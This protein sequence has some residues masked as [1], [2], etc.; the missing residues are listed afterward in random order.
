MNEASCVAYGL[1]LER[2]AARLS[3]LLASSAEG[4]EVHVPEAI[5]ADAVEKLEAAG[6]ALGD[7]AY[8]AWPPLCRSGYAIR[9]NLGH[10]LSEAL[11]ARALAHGRTPTQEARAI[12]ADALGSGLAAREAST[13]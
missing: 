4:G 10:R 13:G 12:L 6:A 2:C 1:L 3:D 5:L 8:A 9:M 7:L 11:E